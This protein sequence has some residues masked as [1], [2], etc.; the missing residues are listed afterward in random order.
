MTISFRP[1][2]LK[3][4]YPFKIS[5]FSRSFTPI[6]LVEINHE[7]QTGLG[8]ASMVPYMGESIDS[9][10]SFLAKVDLKWLKHPFNFDEVIHYLDSI[11][12]GNP[13]IKAAI[14][15]ALH[16]LQGKIENKPCY[17][18]FGSLPEDM[19]V[20]SVTIGMDTPDI[21]TRK[22]Q[23]ADLAKVLK[24]KLGSDEDKILIETIR[25]VTD[26]PLYVDA[27]QGWT[28]KEH[29]LDLIYWLKEAGVQL[30]E[31]PMIKTDTASNAWIT[32]RS[33]IP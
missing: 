8:E 5:G 10:S 32:E 28:N 2:E 21:I 3:L 7:G 24:V 1:F 26:K 27:N 9:A 25:S 14:D 6:M 20:T 31:Q 22:V 29:A 18:F 12:A 15:I 33:P 30:I 17:Q 19:P 4:K 16:D 13:A 11:A 23:E